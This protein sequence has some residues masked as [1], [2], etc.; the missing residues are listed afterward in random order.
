MRRMKTTL[1]I[2]CLCAQA[3]PAKNLCSSS[4]SDLPLQSDEGQE[5]GGEA[6][7]NWCDWSPEPQFAFEGLWVKEGGDPPGGRKSSLPQRQDL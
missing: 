1:R 6:C 5:C 7:L 2:T 4:I 3:V